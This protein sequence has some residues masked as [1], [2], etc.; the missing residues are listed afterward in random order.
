MNSQQ[1]KITDSILLISILQNL[2]HVF[3][4]DSQI[5]QKLQYAQQIAKQC[6]QKGAFNIISDIMKDPKRTDDEKAL[7]ITIYTNAQMF[8]Q[9]Q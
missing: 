7:Y 8:Y 3:P 9:Q 1:N 4:N 5:L 2:E 6:D